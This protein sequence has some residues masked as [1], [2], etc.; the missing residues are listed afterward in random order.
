M[1]EVMKVVSIDREKNKEDKTCP[2][3]KKK[4]THGEFRRTQTLKQLS[5]FKG[6]KDGIETFVRELCSLVLHRRAENL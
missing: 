1:D 6:L 3:T 4:K 2:K 5:M